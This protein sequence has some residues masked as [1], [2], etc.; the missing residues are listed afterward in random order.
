MN[1]QRTYECPDGTPFEVVWPDEESASASWRWDQL[2]GPTPTSPLSAELGKMLLEGFARGAESVGMPFHMQ[3][4]HVNGYGFIRMLPPTSEAMQ[5]LDGVAARDSE[6][7]LHRQVEVWE[8]EYRPEVEAINRALRTWAAPEDT[9]RT[10][11]DRYD[12]LEAMRRR[13]GQLHMIALSLTTVAMDRFERLCAAAFG[14]DGPRIARDAVGGMPNMSLQSAEALWDLSREAQSRPE[15]LALLREER[16]VDVR[17]KLEGVADGLEFRALLD[18]Y[19]EVYGQ[20][21]ESFDEFDFPTWQEDPRFVLFLLRSYVDGTEDASPAA[22][23]AKTAELR[24][25][26]TREAEDR[27]SDAE[28]VEEFRVA[29]RAAQA[30]T[31]L[32]EDHN[33]H[34]DQRGH[35]AARAACLA[36]GDRLS[37][38]GS[39]DQPSDVFY[40]H[41]AEIGAAATDSDVRYQDEIAERRASRAHWM[42][43]LPPAFIGDGEAIPNPLFANFFGPDEFEPAEPG[44]I[45]GVAAS[46]GVVRGTARVILTLEEV[47]KL[48]PGEIL[49][50][51][52]TAPPWTPLFAVAGAVVTDSGGAL[53]HCAIVA[54]EYGIPAVTG[55]KTGT[56]AIED[57]MLLPVDGTEGLVRIEG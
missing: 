44:S 1:L 32:S 23:H 22:L 30:H 24:E 55:T 46:G 42:R 4:M 35:V 19:L 47:D 16:P 12:E 2:H 50:T 41:K 11:F 14:D 39:V 40:L 49:V 27:L 34:I 37:A 15:V 21:N 53:S 29:Q 18:S 10:L 26:T 54:R 51:Y 3:Q 13:H 56:A 33:Y 17:S 48:A 36:L 57:G 28:Q 38:Q 8:T 5:V 7:R 25:Q 31:I 45:R 9:L 43:T 52:A 20:R 6:R